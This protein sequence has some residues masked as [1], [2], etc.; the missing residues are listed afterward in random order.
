MRQIDGQGHVNE[1]A[2]DP[3]HEQ[4]ESYL[5]CPKTTLIGLC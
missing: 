4:L 5:F 3:D 1:R 2:E